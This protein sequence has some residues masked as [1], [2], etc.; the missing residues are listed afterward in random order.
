MRNV[1]AAASRTRGTR[2]GRRL[3]AAIVLASTCLALLATAIQLYLDYARDVSEIDS[4]FS[5]IQSAYLDSLGSSLWSFDK[6][7]TRLQL[8]GMLKMRDLRYV[9]V[10]GRAG[11]QF[12]AGAQPSG[13]GL[14]RRYELHAPTAQREELGTLTVVASF[15]GVYRRLIDRSL[16]ILVTQGT[17]TFFIAL[18][19]LYIVSVWVTRHLERIAAHARDYGAGQRGQV[20][21]LVRPSDHAPD[22][23][24]DVVAAFT[25][26]SQSLDTELTRRKAV[27]AELLA[28]RDQLEE[29]VARRTAELQVAKEQADAA[30]QAK[31]RFLANMSHELRTPLNGILGYAQVLEMSLPV[32]EERLRAGLDVIRV[33]GEH[34]LALIVDILDLARVE[35][36]KVELHPQRL[37]PAVLLREVAALMRVRAHAKGLHFELAGG[38]GLPPAIW[39]DPRILR[40]V[41]LNLL[42][43]AVKF[44]DSGQVILSVLTLHA[45]DSRADLRFE[46]R[47]SGVG[48]AADQLQNIFDPFVQV[49]DVQRRAGGTGL[50]LAISRQLVRRMG[51]EIHVESQVGAGSRFWFDL[52]FPLIELAPALPATARMPTGY[53]GPRQRILIV[54]DVADNRN[55][56]SDSLGALGF[57]LDQASDGR[58]ALEQLERLPPDLIVMDMAMPVLSGLD[59][60][61]CIRALPGHAKLPIIAVS[62]HASNSDRA[63]CLAAGASEFMTKPI[64]I[65]QLLA[66]TAQLLRLSWEVSEIGHLTLHERYVR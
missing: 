35:A 38:S 52:G 15:D 5:Q 1:P 42:G 32:S 59:A 20:L 41:L 11:E 12:E 25:E 39:A 63:N 18:F 24:D 13:P 21:Q 17:K 60:M 9:Q 33:S 28:H 58:Q 26:M 40:Q 34:L 14:T 27:E 30:N 44:T 43:N 47:D 45:S 54:D 57:E 37:E 23:L 66:L 51:G 10:R 53:T 46:V 48:I 50:G 6:N 36:D 49:G 64:D 3:L 16:V 65:A 4:E 7:Q 62:A 55:M 8:N 56:L 22:E 29:T 31:S 2:L 61:R 19:I